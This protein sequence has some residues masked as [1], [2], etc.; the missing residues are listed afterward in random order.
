MAQDVLEYVVYQENELGY[1]FKTTS[2]KLM[3]GILSS[4][5]NGRNP[6]TSTPVYIMESE[7]ILLRAATVLDFNS[8][9][10]SPRGHLYPVCK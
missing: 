7:V 10:V 8:F 4:N 2:G 1:L 3:M 6:I 9:R 5:L